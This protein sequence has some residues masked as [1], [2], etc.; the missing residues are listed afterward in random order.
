MNFR[1]V[2]DA[3]TALST[4]PEHGPERRGMP[5]WSVFKVT[6]LL[7]PLVASWPGISLTRVVIVAGTVRLFF[8]KPV[9]T[10][11]AIFLFGLLIASM[12]KNSRDLQLGFGSILGRRGQDEQIRTAA[13]QSVDKAQKVVDK[14]EAKIGPRED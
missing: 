9:N 1:R 5:W 10:P 12:A 3:I 2:S 6:F 8:A 4:K 7:A 14:I 13:E 11:E